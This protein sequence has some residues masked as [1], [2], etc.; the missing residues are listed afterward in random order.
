M[1]VHEFRVNDSGR[2]TLVDWGA[3][4]RIVN[5]KRDGTLGVEGVSEYLKPLGER[6]SQQQMIEE[7]KKNILK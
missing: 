7:I 5:G 4:S 3:C 6:R 2:I 1:R